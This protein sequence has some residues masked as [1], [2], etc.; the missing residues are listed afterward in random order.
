MGNF[1]NEPLK[2]AILD[3]YEGAENQGM[4]CIREIL[5]KFADMQGRELI[6][7]EFNVRQHNEL[8]D[9]SY[10]IYISTGGP[11]SPLDS[12]GSLWENSFF[13]W[14]EKVEKYNS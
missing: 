11:G 5:N 10:D 3:M 13:E 14:I 2:V 7:D 4:R 9:F 1:E 6:R 8:P 12:E